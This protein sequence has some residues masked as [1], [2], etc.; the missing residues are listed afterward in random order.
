MSEFRPYKHLS[1]DQLRTNIASLKYQ[2]RNLKPERS[3]QA[4]NYYAPAIDAFEQELKRRES[5]ED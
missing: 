1:A 3:G 5:T 2:M 4:S